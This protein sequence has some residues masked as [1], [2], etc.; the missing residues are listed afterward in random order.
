MKNEKLFWIAI[1][2][3]L[4][5]AGLWALSFHTLPVS[6][7]TDDWS[8]FGSYLGGVTGPLLSFISIILVLRTISLTQKNHE[9]QIK[10]IVQ[11]QTYAKFND[12]C[13][14]LESAVNRSWLNE[15]RPYFQELIDDL[16]TSV[17][18]ND[19]FREG[20]STHNYA[21]TFDCAVI[22][23]RRENK[24]I[25]EI[26]LVLESILKH[27][28]SYNT[29]DSALM[30]N[31]LELRLTKKQRLIIFLKLRSDYPQIATLLSEHWPR[32]AVPI[33]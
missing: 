32:F 31:M 9:E 1:V 30:K 28:L 16:K 2:S 21:I 20:D 17:L 7:K 25:D 10:L 12:L 23:L 18:W 14:Y 11:E 4:I 22:I 26:A 6:N 15:E 3:L 5:S 29:A 33:F 19:R 8:N 27:I 13:E 24:S